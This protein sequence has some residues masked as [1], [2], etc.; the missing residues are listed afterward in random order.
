MAQKKS[1][2]KQKTAD[3]DG[4]TERT[5]PAPAPVPPVESQPE[6]QPIPVPESLP[7]PVPPPIAKQSPGH[8]TVRS[9]SHGEVTRDVANAYLSIF[10]ED[11]HPV[12]EQEEFPEGNGWGAD[13]GIDWQGVDGSKELGND[14]GW[15]DEVDRES[16][17]QHDS[18]E[19]GDHGNLGWGQ[20]GITPARSIDQEQPSLGPPLDD[21]VPIQVT[22]TSGHSLAN[23]SSSAPPLSSSA[24]SVQPAQ[25]SESAGHTNMAT[26][27]D[28][29]QNPPHFEPKNYIFASSMANRNRPSTQP[30]GSAPPSGRPSYY[31]APNQRLPQKQSMSTTNSQR[32]TRL[33]NLTPWGQPKNVDPWGDPKP[34]PILH[35]P[36]PPPLAATPATQKRPAWYDWGRQPQTAASAPL[37]DRRTG[38]SYDYDS[39][40]DEYTDNGYTD[41]D[42]G[43]HDVWGPPSNAQNGWASDPRKVKSDLLGSDKGMGA[44]TK[45]VLSQAEHA[46]I[47]NVMLNDVHQ[48]YS[49]YQQQPQKHQARAPRHHPEPSHHQLEKARRLE[50]IAEEQRRL[51]ME[52]EA[53]QQQKTHK[54]HH[55]G[56]GKSS[57]KH[58]HKGDGLHDDNG[59]S[60][61]DEWGASSGWVNDG[62][63][64]QDDN[65]WGQSGKNGWGQ[66][67]NNWGKDGGN[68]WGHGGDDRNDGGGG[69]GWYN[70]EDTWGNNG[71]DGWN[72]A[73]GDGWN[74]AGGDGWN[75]A[76]GDGWNNDG[77]GG[78]G[79]SGGNGWGK[80]NG[81]QVKGDTKKD[82]NQG[83]TWAGHDNSWSNTQGHND[84]GASDWD[85]N[86]GWGDGNDD[87]QAL[88]EAEEDWREASRYHVLTD[89]VQ[90]QMSKTF[91]Q[92]ISV[93]NPRATN[94]S[95]SLRLGLPQGTINESGRQAF[96]P[97]L[98]AIFGKERLTRDRIHWMYA[99]DNEAQVTSILYWIQELERY[100]A[101]LGLLKFLETKER[102]AL[103][104]NVTFRLM[105]H[106]DKPVFD[107]LG[108]KQVQKS[109][110][111]ILQ[112]SILAI[113]PAEQTVIFVYL[114]SRTGNSVAMWRRKLQ[115][116]KDIQQKHLQALK[117]VK[118]GLRPDKDLI[119]VDEL[120]P[121]DKRKE[122][123]PAKSAGKSKQAIKAEPE[124]S[125]KSAGKLKQATK[126]EPAKLKKS[127]LKTHQRGQSLP[128]KKSRKW[129]QI[130]R[131]AD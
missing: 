64:G 41:D 50:Q 27:Q 49:G 40:D 88:Y 101:F 34:E 24:V 86:D 37:A 52:M 75:N 81:G 46:Q 35:P 78:W 73:G 91:M 7:L 128:T 120:P 12:N 28:K 30:A 72:N 14:K 22:S 85:K 39:E 33:S 71:G 61:K 79:N 10:A 62:G 45:P 131:F 109:R 31:W 127:A 36:P 100:L 90:H 105:E 99:P 110:D 84:W 29:S 60:T 17:G 58:K 96:E 70:G 68:S 32:N 130:L 6:Q 63:R 67:S 2:A 47:L 77:G 65:S 3:K 57:K 59:W 112:H 103:F 123:K 18:K 25:S 76:G 1:K 93:E 21:R 116:P 54:Q 16:E 102:G 19:Y 92:A 56:A 117:K 118:A 113:D 97:A 80:G 121:S 119:Y 107:W 5:L 26:P 95:L 94:S 82:K 42:D 106:P 48:G 124:K 4:K 13:D 38:D 55:E 69:D 108:Y 104:V 23:P 8:A 129:W 98:K 122:A 66:S 74:N 11:D 43:T 83:D 126:A 87:K 20:T 89:S 51:A 44:G 9:I 111:R 115:V 114:L 125:P 53:H 15:S